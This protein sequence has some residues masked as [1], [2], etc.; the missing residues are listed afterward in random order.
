MKKEKAKKHLENSRKH[1]E[2]LR[3]S[4]VSTMRDPSWKTLNTDGWIG[5]SSNPYIEKLNDIR[6]DMEEIKVR[7]AKFERMAI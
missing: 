2:Y 3:K 1:L 7:I 5:S 4:Y 6:K